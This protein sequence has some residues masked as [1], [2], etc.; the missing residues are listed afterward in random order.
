MVLGEVKIFKNAINSEK[1]SSDAAKVIQLAA[2][3]KFEVKD[4]DG[5]TLLEAINDTRRVNVQGTVGKVGR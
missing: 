4:A 2:G 5:F 3:E 1:L